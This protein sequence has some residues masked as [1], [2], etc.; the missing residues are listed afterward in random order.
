MKRDSYYFSFALAVVVTVFSQSCA[1][2]RQYVVPAAA[3]IPSGG[4]LFLADRLENGDF[5]QGTLGEWP[6]GWHR[7]IPSKNPICQAEIVSSHEKGANYANCKSGGQCAKLEA[8]NVFPSPCFLAEGIDAKAYRGKSFLFRSN[9]RAEIAPPSIVYIMVRVHTP[10]ARAGSPDPMES[11]FYEQVP[12]TSEKWARYEIGGVVD[13][14]AHD[15]ELGLLIRGQ[16]DAWIDRASL[17]FSKAPKYP[18]LAILQ[19]PRA[20]GNDPE[21]SF[22]LEARYWAK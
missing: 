7:W 18:P 6:S 1:R 10:G 14:D 21:S 11:T 17:D 2:P 8:K 15:I 19:S 3:N 13:P 4:T 5:A 16:G 12:V 22:H 20:Q 9:V